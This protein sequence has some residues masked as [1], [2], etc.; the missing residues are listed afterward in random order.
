MKKQVNKELNRIKKIMNSIINENFELDSPND[1]DSIIDCE[2]EILD[3]DTM[4]IVV[5]YDDGD[6]HKIYLVSVDFEYEDSEPQTYDYPGSYGGASGDIDF[7]KMIHPEEKMLTPNEVNE[8]MSNDK[9]NSC[10]YSTIEK[11]E[12]DAFKNYSDSG[13]DTDDYHDRSRE[14]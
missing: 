1:N 2:S 8:L 13:P 11:M 14:D 3:I 9:V 5:T 12:Y 7:I 6:R 4:E 10:V